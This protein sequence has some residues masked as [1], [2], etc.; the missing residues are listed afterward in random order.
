VKIIPLF[1]ASVVFTAGPDYVKADVVE[2][3]KV[4]WWAAH[5]GFNQDGRH[6]CALG[7]EATN[8]RGGQFVVEH[9]AD[10]PHVNVRMVKP[11]WAIPQGTK[12]TVGFAFGYGAPQNVPVIGAGTEL[13]AEFTS[14]GALAFLAGFR[15]TNSLTISFNSGNEMPWTLT[16]AGEGVVE[17]NFLSCIR[18][19]VP[20]KPAPPPTQPF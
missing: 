4:A 6:V 11:S 19:Q 3:A 12:A 17:P 2:L 5:S 16:G 20:A 9:L 8:V 7:T 13:R 10:S 18:S 15:S 1:I 14:Q